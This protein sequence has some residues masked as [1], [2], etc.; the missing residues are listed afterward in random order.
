LNYIRNAAAH[1]DAA[2]LRNP[3]P[4]RE[5]DLW[6]RKANGIWSVQQPHALTALRTVMAT[7]NLV[8]T[9]LAAATAQPAPSLTLPETVTYP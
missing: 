4:R 9:E 7:F 6:L 8:A 5:G 2:K 1:G 3:P